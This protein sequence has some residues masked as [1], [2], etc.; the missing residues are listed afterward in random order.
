VGSWWAT[1]FTGAPDAAVFLW[2]TTG[3]AVCLTA[4]RRRSLSTS[5]PRPKGRPC[6]EASRHLAEAGAR[7]AGEILVLAYSFTSRPITGCPD[8]RPTAGGVNVEIVLD[9]SNEKERIHPILPHLL[10]ARGP[11]TP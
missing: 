1:G 2:T 9:H 7:P 6:T 11:Q 5:Y 10:Q 8:C 4:N 3:P